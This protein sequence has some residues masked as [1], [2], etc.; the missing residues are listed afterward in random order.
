MPTLKFVP[1]LEMVFFP[2]ASADA[3]FQVS[4]A[5]WI[6][7]LLVCS[8]LLCSALLCSALLCSALLCSALLCSALLCNKAC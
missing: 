5:G 2:H 4:I 8:A 1:K 7:I 3:V 6:S